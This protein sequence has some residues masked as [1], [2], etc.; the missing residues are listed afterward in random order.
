MRIE[1]PKLSEHAGRPRVAA[2]VIWEDCDRPAMDVYFETVSAFGDAL[3]GGAEAFLVG[4][5][6]PAQ[7]HGEKRILVDGDVCPE[8]IRGV[9]T[10]MSWLRHWNDEDARPLPSIEAPRRSCPASAAARPRAGVLMSG[11]VDS[12]AALRANRLDLP[13]SHPG[14]FE[15]AVMVYGQN[16]ESDGRPETF[17]A[18]MQALSSVASDAGVDL[19]PVYTN[20]R[21]LD[22]TPELFKYKFNSATI[23]SV[24]QALAGRLTSASIA[25]S[26]DIATLHP[27]WGS[28]PLVDPHYSSCR[29]RTHHSDVALSRFEKTKLL[30]GWGAGLS[31]IRV[32]PRNWPGSNCGRCEKCLRTMLALL[33]LGALGRCTA[34]PAVNLTEEL[35][36]ESLVLNDMTAHFYPELLSPLLA[37]G[38]RDLVRG[39]EYAMARYRGEIGW[40]GAVKRFDRQHLNGTLFALKTALLGVV[41]Q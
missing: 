21:D 23:A 37:I 25:S 32:C 6:V 27:R 28:H 31:S 7:H 34:F 11:G 38:R 10:A 4:C 35:L 41:S 18:A 33:A 29:V 15:D 20:V 16:W 8:L 22:N 14:S 12:L 1:E 40:R 3:S 26:Y 36:R 2:R 17:E 19:I 39:V 30:A 9:V 13:P 5:A 24:G